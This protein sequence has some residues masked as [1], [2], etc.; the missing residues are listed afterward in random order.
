MEKTTLIYLEKNNQYLMLHRNKKEND[1]NE[2]FWIG[3]GGHV[4]SGETPE[5]TIV[6]EVKEET[7][8]DLLSFKKRGL[9]YFKNDDFEEEMYLYTSS[10]FKGDIIS[11][12][13]GDL[14]WV[15]I[16]KV[17]ELPIWEGDKIFLKYL[18]DDEPYF[19][20][21]LIYKKKKLVTWNRVK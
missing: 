2:G 20:L 1:L 6:R 18:V 15:D 7:G 4:E 10:D 13:E 5:Q 14:H 3:V 8:L 12:N 9:I 17:M 11:C 21:K 16:S 19:E